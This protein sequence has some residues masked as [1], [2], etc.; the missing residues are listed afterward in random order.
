MTEPDDQ[1]RAYADAVARSQR[2]VEVGEVVGRRRR[3]PRRVLALAAAALTVVVAIAVVAATRPDDGPKGLVVAVGHDSTT[4][5]PVVRDC[6]AASLD[7]TSTTAERLDAGWLPP[8]FAYSSGPKQDLGANAGPMYLGPPSSD[9]PWIALAR[10]HST[11]PPDQLVSGTNRPVTVQGHA[12]VASVGVPV[13]T[14]E[15]IAWTQA[16][17][18]V[19]IV[20]GHLVPEADLLHVAEAVEYDAGTPFTYPTHPTV[21]VRRDHALRA[22]L[23]ARHAVLTS[24]GELDA[25]ASAPGEASRVPTIAP[26]VAVTRPVWVAWSP[27]GSAAL[28]VD[29]QTGSMIATIPH[30]DP[31][32]LASLT[33]RSQPTCAPPFGVLTRSEVEFLRPTEAGTTRTLKLSTQG[34][35]DATR[36]FA[37]LSQC[38]LSTCDPNVPAWLIVDSAADHRY[39]DRERGPCCGTAPSAPPGSWQVTAVDARTGPQ[40]SDVGN[41]ASLGPGAPPADLARVRDLAPA[42]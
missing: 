15:N 42:G 27:D 13:P 38:A 2:P 35:L 5:P 26:D 22:K 31:R 18:T 10:R 41:G 24:F 29:A 23:S 19:L 12:G 7:V 40:S 25:V 33:D 11:L 9:R 17:G 8:G 4:I 39:L 36:T 16:P 37:D 14:F 28:V 34:A 21:T 1:V 30:V 3:R 20:T 6:P 32:A